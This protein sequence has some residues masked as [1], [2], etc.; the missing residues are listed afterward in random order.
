M[1]VSIPRRRILAQCVLALL[2]ALPFGAGSAMAAERQPVEVTKEMRCPVCG[3]YP[4]QYPAW[5]AQIIF[6]DNEAQVF[7]SPVDMFRFLLAMPM[8]DKRHTA[9]EVDAVFVTDF[10]GRTWVNGRTAFYVAGSDAKGP[11]REANLP[12]FGDK[13]AAIAFAGQ[14]GGRVVAF[15]EVTRELLRSLGGAA[16]HH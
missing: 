7:D 6:K 8:F 15:G 1:T 11:M 13:A 4:A 9:A 2:T 3:M 16:H 10:V 12:A 5:R 14:H